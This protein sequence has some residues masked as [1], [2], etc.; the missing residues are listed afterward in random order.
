[1]RK[2]IEWAVGNSAGVNILVALVLIGGFLSFFG[3]RRETFPE[4][5]LD[6]IL[7]SVPY[8]GATPDEVESGICQKIEEAVQ[9]L[10][11]IKKLTSI[12]RE[13]AGFTL[14]Q[15]ETSVRDPQRILSEIRSAV[16]RV[17]VFFP[18]RSEK[19]TVEQVVFRL[20]AIR[21]AVMG[22]KAVMGPNDRS[23]DS[24]ARLR[25]YVEQVRERLL[26][27]PSVSQAQILNAK[28]YQIDV[29]VDED[30]L[31]KYGL[32][33][34]QIAQA[35]RRENMELP[36]GQMKTDGQEILLRGKNKS[37]FGEDIARLPLIT[38]SNGA[39][40]HIGDIGNVRDAF[41]DVTAI[42]EINGRPAM[43][44]SIERTSAEDLLCISDEVK[45]LVKEA[46]V[47]DGY[48]LKIWGD[49]S[50]DVRDRI[51]M[52]RSNG[53]QGGVIV[54]LLLAMFLNLR[55]AF[56]V[57]MGIP[58][59]VF[60]AGSVLLAMGDTLNM[61]TMFAFLM[62]VGI[63]VDDGIVIGENIFEHRRLGKTNRQAAIDGVCEVLPSVFSSVATT[64]IAFIPLF[65]VSG[66]M[67]KFIAVMPTAI[68]AM[69]LI[70]LAEATFALPGHLSHEPHEPRTVVERI[71]HGF[72]LLFWPIEAFFEFISKYMNAA[73]DRF[74][75]G[76]YL[77]LLKFCFRYPGMPI[78]ASILAVSLAFGMVRSGW[79]AFEFFPELD[80][81][82]LIG[83]IIYP[84]GTPVSVTEEAAHRMEAAARRISER[85]AADEES[86]GIT[87][88]PPPTAEDSPR[89]PV[90]MTYLQV[91][92]AAQGDP[93]GGDRINGSHV[94]QVQVELHEATMRSVTSA[95]IMN[96]WRKEAGE[97][98]GADRVTYQAANMGPGGQPLEFKILA[99]RE[100]VAELEAAV[101][102]AKVALRT[103]VGV[104]DISDDS[105]PGKFEFNFKIKERAQSLKLT[106]ADLSETVRNAYYGAE[107]MRLQRGRHEVKLM[108]RY[109]L[110]KRRSLAE[111][112]ELRIRGPDGVERPLN[113]LA[114]ITHSRGYSEINRLDQ[115][116]SITVSADI[117]T[118]QGN[119]ALVATKLQETLVPELLAKY[120]SL[121]FRWE[122]QQQETGESF[123][124]LV[125]GFSIAMMSM[126]MLLV[127]E[128]SSYLQ[129]LIILAIIPFSI[130]AAIFGHA[131]MHLPLTLFSMFGMVTLAGVVVNDSIVLVDFIN[132]CIEKQMPVR[133]ALLTAGSRRLRAVFLTS[134]TTIAGLLPMLLEKSFQ[135]QVLIPMAT[136]LAFGLIGSTTLV[137]LMV[138]LLYQLYVIVGTELE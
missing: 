97:F 51:R 99:P 122:G 74:G 30:A 41:D 70:S 56:W 73:L 48:A 129:P 95:E 17:S 83:Q 52:L 63:V 36:S 104:Y 4:F 103:F 72:S 120:P 50:V 3:M 62:A 113:E 45:A 32:T 105:N 108:V 8:P 58:I 61:L 35:I 2:A 127:F 37:E 11:G 98:V 111:L 38:E 40:L 15:L 24:E 9:S 80:G 101:E 29:E 31:R 114:E 91:G 20:P 94:A 112:D 6:V 25:T 43:V 67:G 18:E 137:L 132:Q 1:M 34:S 115:L 79:V 119:A 92:T 87:K 90:I 106:N 44:I 33:L 57:A 123:F 42:S 81:R 131:L 134:V 125:I 76:F 124:S 107:A 100:K 68:I 14:V 88:T 130:V 71:R 28:A 65:Y 21:V 27:L 12:C 133:E 5:Q 121:R 84:D 26:E 118:A 116:R 16:D 66:V 55:L 109:P 85:I 86:K 23:A 39:V 82:T 117:D 22:P 126:Y 135:A 110:E 10:S 47:P 77:P 46:T 53:I 59:S 7:V 138:P 102:A 13:G 136:S 78:G 64:I 96:L 19:S 54:F 75:E 69:L 89:G 93:A 60:G 49:E 128:F